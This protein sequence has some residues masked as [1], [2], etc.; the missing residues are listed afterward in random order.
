MATVGRWVCREEWVQVRFVAVKDF[1]REEFIAACSRWDVGCQKKMTTKEATA[2]DTGHLDT[3]R[4]DIPP[5]FQSAVGDELSRTKRAISDMINAHLGEN[6]EISGGWAA[7]EGALQD[8]GLAV[9]SIPSPTEEFWAPLFHNQ[10]A[11]QGWEWA[12]DNATAK[13]DEGNI[14][15][16]LKLAPASGGSGGSLKG[17]EGSAIGDYLVREAKVISLGEALWMFGHDYTAAELYQYFCNCRR[18]STKRPHAWTN[19]Q[20]R[21]AVLQ[22]KG[23]TGR[24]GF[25]QRGGRWQHLMDGPGLS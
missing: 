1:V 16:V 9:G 22:H 19:P 21:D 15:L 17:K 14:N 6:R 2:L 3:L 25:G 7:L 5:R 10:F 23:A 12:P 13:D 8:A 20:R 24:W 18:L 4:S 11:M